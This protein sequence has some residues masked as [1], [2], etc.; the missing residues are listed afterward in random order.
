MS[1]RRIHAIVFRCVDYIGC[2]GSAV[3]RADCYNCPGLMV[4]YFYSDMVN[5]YKKVLFIK[6][7]VLL[8]VTRHVC[9]IL[10]YLFFFL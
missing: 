4:C 7:S 9:E 6:L 8:Y 5:I 3:V 1:S 2:C 10:F